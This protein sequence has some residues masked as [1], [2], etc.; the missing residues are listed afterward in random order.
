MDANRVIGRPQTPSPQVS[1]C[2]TFG[3]AWELSSSLKVDLAVANITLR[4]EV[5]DTALHSARERIR[6]STHASATARHGT[7]RH[8]HTAAYAARTSS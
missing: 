5:L 3:Y 7:P 8:A 4:F 1:S 2:S 6:S